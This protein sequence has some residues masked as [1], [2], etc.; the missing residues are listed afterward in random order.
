MLV[1]YPDIEVHYASF[2]K[3]GKSVETVSN[4]A[5]EQS[6]GHAK[7]IRFHALSGRTYAEAVRSHSP[8][9]DVD[10]VELALQRSGIKGISQLCNDM[11]TYLM[12]WSAPEYLDIYKDILRV[13]DEVDPIVVAVDPL[14][15]PG[16]DAVRAHG[17]N[18]VVISPNSLKDNF[19]S[20]QP[21]GSFF[22]KYPA[23]VHPKI[24]RSFACS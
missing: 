15:G 1:D 17:R 23:Y 8:N 24:L 18:H 10:P 14:F 19:G 9:Q 5:L 3:L 7:P 16:L 13:L 2:K 6:S 22:W 20:M 21:W 12:P 4:F 11:Q